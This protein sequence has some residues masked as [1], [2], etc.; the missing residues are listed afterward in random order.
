M[1]EYRDTPIPKTPIRRRAFLG[2][3]AA[4]LATV[5]AAALS[6]PHANGAVGASFSDKLKA[7]YRAD[8]AQVQTFYRVNRYPGQ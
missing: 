2:A 1:N 4:G 7:R 3:V 5:S 8:S 6:R